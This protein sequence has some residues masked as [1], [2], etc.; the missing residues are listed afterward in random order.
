MQEQ[1]TQKLSDDQS[2]NNQ[3]T[4]N[5]VGRRSFLSATVGVAASAAAALAGSASARDYG[6]NAQPAGY[7][8]PGY[9]RAGRS[10]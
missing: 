7:P 8:R 5:V 3:S 9:R 4:N 10:V 6:P 2:E 1:S